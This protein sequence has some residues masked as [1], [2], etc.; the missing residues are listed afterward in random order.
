MILK[1][2]FNISSVFALEIKQPYDCTKL[3]ATP[4]CG[5]G[6]TVGDSKIWTWGVTQQGFSICE[7]GSKRFSCNSD[8]TACRGGMKYYTIPGCPE[9]NAKFQ[10]CCISTGSG[11]TFTTCYSCTPSCGSRLSSC[12][13]LG[14]ATDGTSSCTK[15]DNCGKN[16][17]TKTGGACYKCT[18]PTVLATPTNTYLRVGSTD[19]DLSTNP[20]TPTIVD[21]R[22]GGTVK[23]FSNSSP[24]SYSY[25]AYNAISGGTS[26]LNYEGDVQVQPSS[27]SL[28]FSGTGRFSARHY[29]KICPNNTNQYSGTRTGYYCMETNVAPPSTPNNIGMIIDGQTYTLSSSASAPTVVKYP[30]GVATT[31]NTKVSVLNT[32]S[33]PSTASSS[34]YRVEANNYGLSGQ[35]SPF[36]CTRAEDFCD[37]GTSNLRDFSPTNLPLLDVLKQGAEGKIDSKYYNVNTCDSTNIYS[38]AISRY[39]KVNNIPRPVDPDPINPTPTVCPVVTNTTSDST[40]S[41]QCVSTTY[42]GTEVNNPLKLTVDGKDKD[43]ND[44]VRG[45]VIWLS[46]NGT[47]GEIPQYPGIFPGYTSSNPD[48]IA[49]MILK[50]GTTWDNPL[51]YTADSTNS[52]QWGNISS[53]KEIRNSA[54]QW[55]S[56]ISSTSI[57]QTPE[58][59]TFDIELLF[60]TNISAGAYPDGSYQ[61]NSIVFDQHMLLAGNILDQYYM[62]KNCKSGGWNIDLIRPTFNEG[63]FGTD[64][65]PRERIILARQLF[66]DWEIGDASSGVSNVVINAYS[67]STDKPLRLLEPTGQGPI[68]LEPVPPEAE[69]GIMTDSN[70]WKVL[71]SPPRSTFKSSARIDIGENEEGMATF[72]VTGFDQACNDTLGSETINL[73]PWITAKGGLV[74]SGG[75]VGINAKDVTGQASYLASMLK[76]VAVSELDIATELV[77]SRSDYINN[78]IH[79]NLGA[80]RAHSTYNSNSKKSFWFNYLTKRL[81]EQIASSGLI[82]TRRANVIGIP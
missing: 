10:G 46:K 52:N 27:G 11:C 33:T 42:T 47:G 59:V 18:V 80:V 55:F 82:F 51:I 1:L 5:A 67:S 37:E 34:G 30:S 28:P 72:Y 49:V 16:C 65:N 24:V 23:V 35:W 6:G 53:H 48:H 68:S 54:G 60:N 57:T 9:S 56:R 40:S 22:S 38:G 7:T 44:E 45:A 41:R 62:I 26:I 20:G 29:Q 66:L 15:Y 3:P 31:T 8:D 77:S 12:T 79:S 39:Y 4:Y 73:N 71:S 69:I 64:P 14:C 63:A 75:S 43:G 32:R 13:G 21:Y 70:T 61:M 81:Q 17:G 50:N 36:G 25:Q 19:Y 76:R 74:Y 58:V 2:N 78:F